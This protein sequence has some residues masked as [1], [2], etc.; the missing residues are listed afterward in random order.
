[1]TDHSLRAV[2]L[3]AY[4]LKG[5][6][7]VTNVNAVA[8][9]QVVPSGLQATQTRCVGCLSI[10]SSAGRL[11]AAAYAWSWPGYSVGLGRGSL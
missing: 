9:T 6:C 5:W 2:T 7:A 11:E 4:I 3:L 8:N 1:M 10:L